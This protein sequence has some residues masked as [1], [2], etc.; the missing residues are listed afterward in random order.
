MYVLIVSPCREA[1]GEGWGTLAN[2]V[3]GGSWGISPDDANRLLNHSMLS[4]FC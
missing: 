3:P 2:K 4:S 1:G